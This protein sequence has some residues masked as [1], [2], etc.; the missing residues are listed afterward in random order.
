LSGGLPNAKGIPGLSGLLANLSLLTID[1]NNLLM[2]QKTL[3]E[4][5]YRFGHL[6]LHQVQFISGHF[7]FVKQ[8]FSAAA[9]CII[10]LCE[11]CEF[12]KASCLSKGAL[13]IKNKTHD[14]SL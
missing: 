2:G 5:R 6:G 1:N 7:R 3:L 8:R 13:S 4:W 14:I 11:I 10:P 9:K 12:A